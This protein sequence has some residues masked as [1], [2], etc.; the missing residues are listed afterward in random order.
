MY[1]NEGGGEEW[2]D[3]E[4]KATGIVLN[5]KIATS[6]NDMMDYADLKET[7][8]ID[9]VHVIDG[10]SVEE[11]RVEMSGRLVTLADLLHMLSTV[12][13]RW[14]LSCYGIKIYT[15]DENGVYETLKPIDL[16]KSRLAEIP[17]ETIDF[18]Y[19]LLPQTYE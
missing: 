7:D 19:N 2:G 4:C 10:G 11:T 6:D 12:G 8:F 14:V 9:G 1:H 3:L 5:G 13:V 15:S 16:Q 17:E 18:I